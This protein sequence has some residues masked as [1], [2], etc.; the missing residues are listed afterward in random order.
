MT[1]EASS[2]RPGLLR[3]AAAGAWHVPAGFV[4]LLRNPSLLSLALV[5]VLLAVVFLVGGLGLGIVLGPAVDARFAP[6][7]DRMSPGVVFIASLLLWV[8]TIG[9]SIALG[10]AVALLLSAPVLDLLSRRVEAR[11]RGRADEEDKG[12]GFAVGQSLLGAFYFLLAAPGVFLLGLIPL[13]GPILAAL[14][15]ARALA[16]QF[17]D[18]TLGRRGLTFREKRVWHRRWL[19]ESEGFGLAGMVTLLIPLANVLMAPALAAGGTL[20][21]LELEDLE[22]DE[23]KAAADPPAAAPDASA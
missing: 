18:P 3:R 7:P 13:V 2:G 22:R 9:A 5:P 20:L 1:R 10:F 21:V 17:T 12:L 16:F 8:G 23:T 11:V 4:Y 15:G 14:W 19:P 6:S